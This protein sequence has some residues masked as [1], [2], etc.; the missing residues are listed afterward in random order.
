[1]PARAG[2]KRKLLV[3]R[4]MVSSHRA[5]AAFEGPRRSPIEGGHVQALELEF[6]SC[7]TEAIIGAPKT[8]KAMRLAGA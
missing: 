4:S 6:A 8:M 3:R 2:K 7:R 1:M 5:L